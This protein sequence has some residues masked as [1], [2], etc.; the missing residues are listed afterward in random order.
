MNRSQRML[1]SLSTV[2]VE[3]LWRIQ[4]TVGER[5]WAAHNKHEAYFGNGKVDWTFWLLLCG[6]W[7]AYKV[8]ASMDAK[9]EHI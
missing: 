5:N 7:V 8:G 6:T 2:Q 1:R 9:N 4:R 3:V